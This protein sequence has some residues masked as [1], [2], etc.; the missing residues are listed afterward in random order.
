M[1]GLSSQVGKDERFDSKSQIKA[2]FDCFNF[3]MA[4]VGINQVV[5]MT[6]ESEG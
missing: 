3:D 1:I 4:N 6:W 2:I 5:I